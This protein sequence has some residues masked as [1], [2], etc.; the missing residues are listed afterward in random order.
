MNSADYRAGRRAGL[1]EAIALLTIEEGKW[2]EKMARYQSGRTFQA[3]SIRHKA[4]QIAARRVRTALNAHEKKDQARGDD[5][6]AAMRA[7][8]ARL[9]L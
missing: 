1:A 4:Y 7:A 5:T 2:A 8:L 6:S 9:G 3:Q